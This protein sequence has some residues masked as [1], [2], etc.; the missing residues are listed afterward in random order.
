MDKGTRNAVDHTAAYVMLLRGN[1]MRPME[2]SDLFCR[3]VQTAMRSI[4]PMMAVCALSNQGKT[5][6]YG[7]VDVHACVQHR[8]VHRDFH[9]MLA[10]NFYQRFHV[11]KEPFPDLS[12]RRSWYPIKLLV[13]QDRTKPLSYST[14]HGWIT[15]AHKNCGI[16]ISK[17]THAGRGGGTTDISDKGYQWVIFTIHIYWYQPCVL[18]RK[19]IW[20]L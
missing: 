15:K 8:F 19:W 6:Q 7:R 5:N 11:K 14:H 12:N 3:P 1:N 10:L 18:Q 4:T 2:I 16:R 9:T 17:V 13:G 20:P